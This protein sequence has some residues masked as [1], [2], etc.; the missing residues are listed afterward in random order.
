MRRKTKNRLMVIAAVISAVVTLGTVLGLTGALDGSL[1]KRNED[2]LI[3]L[4]AI[5]DAGIELGESFKSKESDVTLTV[6]ENGVVKLKGTA[7]ADDEIVYATLE[8]P[9]GVYRFTGAPDSTKNTYEL[10]LTDGTNVYEADDKDV[11]S[12]AEVGTYNVVIVLY[13]D[14]DFGIFGEK[15]YPVIWEVEDSEDDTVVKFWD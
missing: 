14:C 2:N 10:K 11:I 4:D 12:L 13:E 9:A 3:T 1:R 15:L 5:E 8:L 6:D 7:T